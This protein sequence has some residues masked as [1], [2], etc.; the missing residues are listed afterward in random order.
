LK[1]LFSLHP[2]VRRASELADRG[3]RI[4]LHLPRN[5]FAALFWAQLAGLQNRRIWVVEDDEE[6]GRH[7]VRALSQLADIPVVFLPPAVTEGGGDAFALNERLSAFRHIPEKGAAVI[8]TT[9]RSLQEPLPRPSFYERQGMHIT[10]GDKLD[11]E[12]LNEFLFDLDYERTDLVTT[13]GEFARSGSVVDVFPFGSSVPYRLEFDFEK[14]IRIRT[15]DTGTQLADAEAAGIDILPVPARE[16]RRPAYEFI[17]SEDLLF[18]RHPVRL[19]ELREEKGEPSEDFLARLRPKAFFSPQWD[20]APSVDPGVRSLPAVPNFRVFTRDLEART[21]EGYVHYITSPDPARLERLREHLA[22]VAGRVD[23]RTLEGDFFKGFIDPAT[24]TALIPEHEIFGRPYR[25][26]TSP[27]KRKKQQHL[28]REL[29]EWQKGD[30]IVHEDYGIGIYEGLVKIDKGGKQVEAVKLKYK[31]GDVLFVGIHS[32]YKLSK[33]RSK[34]GKP[35]KIYRLGSGAWERLKQKTKKRVKRL[36]FDLISLYAKRKSQKGFAFAPDSPLQWELESSFMYEDTPDQRRATE[37]VKRDMESDRP[38]DRLVC[39]DVGFGK[40][41]IAVRAA[42]KAVDNGK[43]VAVLVPTTVLAYQHYQT[44]KDRLKNFPVTV[45]YLNRFRS[46]SDRHRIL[47]ELAEGKIDIIIGTHAL[48]S[49]KVRFKDLGLLV[50]DEEQ[51]FGVNVKEK[52]KNLKTGI[53]VLTLTATPIPRTLQF[54]LMGERDLSVIHTPPPNRYPVVTTVTRF[55]P[56]LIREAVRRELDRG[57]QVYVV[58]NR[59]AGIEQVADLIRELVPEAKVALAHGRM[60]GKDLE[61]TM[62][63]FR[64]GKFDV[65]VSTAIVESG[66]DVP[67]ANTMIV[68]DAH[69]FGL[70]DL[71]QLR[72]RVGR[73]DRKAYCYFLIPSYETLSPEAA[74]RMMTLETYTSLGDGFEIAMKDLEIRGAGDILGAEQS[75]FINELGFELYQ[76]ILREAVEELKHE[77]FEGTYTPSFEKVDEVQFQTDRTWQ[78]PDAYIPSPAARMHYY[79]RLLSAAS[80][81]EID[82]IAEEIENRFGPAPEEARL[83]LDSVRLR[84]LAAPLGFERLVYRKDKLTA[85]FTSHPS[86]AESDVWKKILAYAGAHP[87]CCRLGEKDGKYYLRFENLP[88]P[89]ELKRTMQALYDAVFAER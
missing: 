18:F 64:Q 38:M 76:K 55:D 48:V 50:I 16:E 9:P 26:A 5:A 88:S 52:I 82:R 42:F 37:E 47:K 40:T 85:Y 34:D 4:K 63:D 74:K 2:A 20:E 45:E 66:L 86:F 57:G 56:E 39:G 51:K 70:A 32:L 67:N 23:V 68:L 69:R 8:V 89:A 14:V 84:R 36:A 22:P 54:S 13:P 24:R 79:R 21:L 65:L 17:G 62:L 73:S 35:P 75:G 72:G 49:D 29:D 25:T 83:L 28:L 58:R 3:G 11:P 41:E 6:T 53:D 7:L 71:H 12:F 19:E 30:Y 27:L 77:E 46:A 44:F 15:F 80:E 10:A 60:A 61:R 87:G 1:D 33:Y 81:E 59:I 43:Q 31:N 78:F